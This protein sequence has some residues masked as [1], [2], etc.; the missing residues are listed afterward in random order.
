MQRG[1]ALCDLCHNTLHKGH[2]VGAATVSISTPHTLNVKGARV[3]QGLTLC[4]M[5]DV[6]E[7]IG[8][9]SDVT[10]D[11][12]STHLFS[13]HSLLAYGLISSPSPSPSLLPT[14]EQYNT[15]QACHVCATCEPVSTRLTSPSCVQVPSKDSL[16]EPR[17]GV[18]LNV[19]VGASEPEP[20]FPSRHQPP[21]THDEAGTQ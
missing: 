18:M 6:A 19:A 11:K 15:T 9:S 1:D 20:L 7:S 12:A 10:D 3:E 4:A 2:I 14:P 16:Y 21:A 5:G 17:H 13:S 8:R